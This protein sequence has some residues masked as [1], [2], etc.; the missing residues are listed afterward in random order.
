MY[1]SSIRFSNRR[2]IATS[3]DRTGPSDFSINGQSRKL[4]GLGSDGDLA[5]RT[6]IEKCRELPD[7][8]V[9]PPGRDER[10]GFGPAKVHN[11]ER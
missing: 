6:V 11:P 1:F 5:E 4:E 10:L 9:Y 8:Q 7:W 2:V 3:R